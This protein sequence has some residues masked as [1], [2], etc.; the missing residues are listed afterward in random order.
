MYE[1]IKKKFGKQMIRL[2]SAWAN[3]D[4]WDFQEEHLDGLYRPCMFEMLEKRR[5]AGQ[6]SD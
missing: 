4:D 6:K 5:K 2:L 3:L 1:T